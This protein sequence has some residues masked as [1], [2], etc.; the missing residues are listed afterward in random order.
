M[1]CQKIGVPYKVEIAA[2]NVDGTEEANCKFQKKILV[3]MD[4]AEK[5]GM[6][7]GTKKL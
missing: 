7:G 2:R 3:F 1:P 4:L 6:F 5:Q